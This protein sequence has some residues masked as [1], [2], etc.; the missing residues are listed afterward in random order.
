MAL[1]K[2]STDG[3][4]DDAVTTDKLADAIN[5]ERTG[6]LANVVEDTSPQLGGNLD[7]NGN[8]I[9]F[10][11][12]SGASSER[13]TFGNGDDI[14]VYYASSNLYIT[15]ATGDII[16]ENTGG[17]TSNQ[18]YLRGKANENSIAIH[19]NGAVELYDQSSGSASKKL[20]TTSGGVEVFGV[21]QMDDANSHIKL[22]DN[23]RLD[24]GTGNDLRLFHNGTTGNNNISNV[25]GNLYINAT[26]TEVGILI[27]PNAA[28]ELF[29]D[30]SKKL[31]TTSSGCQVTGILWADGIDT[32]DNEALMIGDGDDLQM[33][34]DGT[35]NLIETHNGE[36][37]INKGTSEYLAK[38]IPDGAVELYYDNSKKF[39][40]Y[41]SGIQVSGGIA[42]GASSGSDPIIDNAD[43]GNGNALFVRTNGSARI[44][45][46]SDG[47]LNLWGR[48]ASFSTQTN[49]HMIANDHSSD[50]IAEIVNTAGGSYGLQIRV[51]SNSSGR[52]GLNIY[53][54]DDSQT[55]ASIMMNG[56]YLSRSDDY[57]GYSDV[58]LK[59]NIVDAK[60]QWDDVKAVRV[61]NFNWKDKPKEKLLGVV[62]QELES[63]CPNLIHDIPDKEADKETG[64]LKETGT[65]TKAAKYSI[66]HMKAFKALQEAMARIE[67]LETKVAAL[68]AA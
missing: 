55:K 22:P 64:E 20:E 21:L 19:G 7:V 31:E 14:Q 18:I 30:N 56:T 17:N 2:V 11:D 4:K 29:Y 9:K 53:S 47:I 40:T 5:T 8:L 6:K 65:V 24:I 38:F 42:F 44:K 41:T 45:L 15:Q 43:G 67:T 52:E 32:G 36:I 51:N 16:L 33:Y 68:E 59:D 23:A 49:R 3:V 10:G 37:H 60:S 50:W 62:A 1:T 13:L 35:K 63:I 58:K 57:A 61:R 12:S 66:L 27:K 28:V 39:N 48:G 26:E 25:S 54:D 46:Q 34:H